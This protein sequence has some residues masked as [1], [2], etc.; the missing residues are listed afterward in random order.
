MRRASHAGAGWP[1][2]GAQLTLV[3]GAR[4][5]GDGAQIRGDGAQI[6][7]D[8]AGAQ[9]HGDADSRDGRPGDAG[10]E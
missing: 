3:T 7:G 9:I 8:I 6:R 1:P 10:T 4:I 2:R 5:R